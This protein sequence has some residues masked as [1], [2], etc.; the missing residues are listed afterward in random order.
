[1]SVL[2]V[3][4]TDAFS[5]V[6][7]S[8]AINKLPFVP[9]RAGTII[10]WGERGVASTTLMIEERAGVL[11]IVNPSP[12]GG[13]GDAI[14]KQKRLAHPIAIPHY[15]INDAVYADEVQGVREFGQ[16][17]SLATVQGVVNDRM[18]EFTTDLDATLELQRVGA[19]K[20][21]ILNGD[22]STL[23]NLFDEF[24]VVQES[25]VDF[26]L[27]NANPAAGALRRKVAQ[28]VRLIQNNLGG[29]PIMGIHA[30]CGDNFFDDLLSHVEVRAS[31]LQTPMAAVLRDGYVYPNGLAI[32]G[33]FEFGGIVWEN[34]RGSHGATAFIDTDKCFIFPMGG[35]LFRTVFGPADYIETVNTIGLPRY[36][37][38]FPFPN[39][40]G[41]ALELQTN[42]L[43]YF[44]RP[45][46]LIKGKRT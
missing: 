19:V 13:V 14:P 5:V 41:I 12:R 40:K 2:D 32:Y 30:F 43:S 28:V 34:Y 37:K 39:D 31:Y 21:I 16:E 46:A 35:G 9:G 25:E 45:K 4:K 6:S 1:M 8:E 11:T 36:A 17:Q 3:F 7:L 26:D 15:Q 33:A 10:N 24:G 22:G 29:S 23:V 20:G 38:Q 44:T 42:A 18:A 27:D